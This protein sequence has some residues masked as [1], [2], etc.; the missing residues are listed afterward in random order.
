MDKALKAVA[1]SRAMSRH[2]FDFLLLPEFSFIGFAALVEPLRIANRFNPGAY[3]WRMVSVDGAPVTASNGIAL[4]PEARLSDASSAS[5]VFAIASFNPLQHTTQSICRQLQ[6]RV[7]QGQT[8]GA[9][10]T[11]CFVLAEAGLLQ[12]ESVTL[13]W[14]AVP[15]FQERYPRMAVQGEARF[16]LS[17]RLMASAGAMASVDMVLEVISRDHGNALALQV[18]EQLVSGW[19]RERT[20]HQRLQISAR[21][22]VHNAKVVQVIEQMEQHLEDALPSEALAAHVHITRRQLERLFQDHLQVSPVQFYLR[23]RVERARHLLRQT[24]MGVIE[25]GLA[26]GFASASAFSRAYRRHFGVAP[27]DDRKEKPH[28]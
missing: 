28:P 18:S 10:D 15:A 13:H 7:Q 24:S 23:L 5:V 12:G 11:G 20:D 25:V 6:K 17:P 3:A 27:S 14:E 16:V 4:H 19:V 21:Y 2:V 9:I 8:L 1:Y 22:K 26:C